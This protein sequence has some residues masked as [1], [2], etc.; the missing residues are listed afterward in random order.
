[1]ISACSR[2]TPQ[3]RYQSCRKQCRSPSRTELRI[4][5]YQKYR[6][7]EQSGTEKRT[8]ALQRSQLECWVYD[9]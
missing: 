6:G 9:R 5:A 7:A 4:T 2:W 8:G 3:P 1:L